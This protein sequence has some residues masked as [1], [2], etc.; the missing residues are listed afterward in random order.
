MACGLP[1]AGL[2]VTCSSGC[3]FI[4]VAQISVLS[5]HITSSPKPMEG[6]DKS[7]PEDDRE[8]F[9]GESIVS[10][11]TDLVGSTKSESLLEKARQ[12]SFSQRLVFS[13]RGRRGNVQKRA[14][15]F[16]DVDNDDAK[17]KRQSFRKDG[18][19]PTHRIQNW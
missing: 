7:P 14:V 16:G 8:H 3:H 10:V 6:E 11:M 12:V 2:T 19:E 17:V 13:W 4:R 15:A 18:T 5:H 9:R 1:T